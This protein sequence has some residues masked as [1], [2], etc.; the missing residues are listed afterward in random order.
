MNKLNPDQLKGAHGTCPVVRIVADNDEGFTEINEHDFDAEKGH[1]LFKAKAAKKAADSEAKE[2]SEMT[3]AE[4]VDEL[5]KAGITADASMTKADLL[6]L[7][8]AA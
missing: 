6:A 3:K 5:T 1:V 2:R 4:L 7:F 8:P